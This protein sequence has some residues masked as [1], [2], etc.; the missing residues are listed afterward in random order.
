[1]NKKKENKFD[2]ILNN[3]NLDNNNTVD[4][5]DYI[6][7]DKSDKDINIKIKVSCKNSKKLVIKNQN[8]ITMISN[9]LNLY[10]NCRFVK[11]NC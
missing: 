6:Y 11:H 5:N 3:E 7:D 10:L 2:F 1:M 8:L 9:L 4:N